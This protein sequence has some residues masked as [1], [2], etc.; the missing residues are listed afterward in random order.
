[1]KKRKAE[2]GVGRTDI[3]GPVKIR[4]INVKLLA[5]LLQRARGRERRKREEGRER[6]VRKGK[7][8][9]RERGR[10]RVM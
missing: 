2:R 5:I 10:E 6:D 4:H 7:V 3:G 9:V 1:M 8:K